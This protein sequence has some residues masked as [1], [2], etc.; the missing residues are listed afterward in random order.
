MPNDIGVEFQRL[1]Y[2]KYKLVAV[3]EELES[4][5]ENKTIEELENKWQNAANV[6]QECSFNQ[7]TMKYIRNCPVEVLS[8]KTEE[9]TAELMD[10]QQKISYLKGNVDSIN[11][12]RFSPADSDF[13]AE[14]DNIYAAIRETEER[15][16]STKI[17]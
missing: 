12:M 14:N 7:E 10:V 6:L 3:Q 16:F 13:L 17:N 2:L 8:E 1:E 11:D 5:M 4:S 15:L 9:I